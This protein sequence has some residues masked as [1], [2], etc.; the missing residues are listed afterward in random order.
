MEWINQIAETLSLDGN[1]E[2]ALGEGAGWGTIQVPGCWEAQ[3]YDAFAEGPARCRRSVMIPQAW[4]GKH[5]DLEVEAA[6]YACEI[7]CNGIPVGNHKGL[8]TRFVIDLTSAARA[9]Q[10]NLIE[11]II[12]KPGKRYPMRACLAGFLPDL[13]TTFG[14]IWQPAR[15]RALNAS[16]NDVRIEADFSSGTLRVRAQAETFN[17]E[18]PMGSW[19]VTITGPDQQ[20]AVSEFPA[21]PDLLLDQI[22]AAG[23][24][25]AWSPETPHLYR[26]EI[27]YQVEGRV[28]ASA[29]QRV[30]FRRFSTQGDQL[31]LNDQPFMVRGILSWGW[32]P[33]KIAP[34]HDIETARQEMRRVR[35]MGFNLIKLCLFVPNP[36]YFEAADEEG[37]LLWE[38]LPM[39]LPQVSPELRVD[40]PQEYDKITYLTAQHPSVVV[41]SLGCELNQT[42]DA[43][44]LSQLNAVV[45]SRAQDVLLCD[46]SGSGES[47]G[48]LDF[49]YSDFTDYHPY[50][51]LHYFE[52]LLDHWRRDW[53]PPRPWIFGEF[54]DSDSF[55]NQEEL[56]HRHDSRPWWLTRQN[57]VAAWR[58]EAQAAVDWH[59]R[60]RQAETGFSLDEI[61]QISQRQSLMIRKYTLEALRRRRGMGGYVVTGL[62][63]TPISTSGVWDDFLRPKWPEG[64]FL[65][66][67]D[68]DVLCLDVGRRRRWQ[69]GGDR[70]D[71]IDPHTWWAASPAR[72]DVILH[73]ARWDYLPGETL[74]WSIKTLE[75]EKVAEGDSLIE[76]RIRA[77]IPGRA[78]TIYWHTPAL[79]KAAGY[80]LEITLAPG[81][82]S[83]R[84]PVWV[85]PRPGRP[86]F[87]MAV[88]DPSHRL[89]DFGDWLK[90]AAHLEPGDSLAR[91]RL[92]VTTQLDSAVW[93]WIEA[94]GKAL[95]LQQGEGPLPARRCPFWRE[96]VKLLANH[97][98]W[99]YFPHQGFT[100]LQ[101]FGIASDLAFDTPHLLQ[102][103]PAGTRFQPI[104]RRLDAREFH[105]S[106]YLF[107][108]SFGKGR[109]LGCSLRLQGGAGAQAAGLSRNVSGAAMMEALIHSLDT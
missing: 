31:L 81:V 11:F 86:P 75:G 93:K 54:N 47:Y 52:P 15:L 9:G 100:D 63:D 44:L 101:F 37:M 98:I 46:N 1:W 21:Q 19:Q 14:G 23:E 45:R 58:S 48:G 56:D 41:Y 50:Y 17:P 80:W 102:A 4:S 55:R 36:A 10:E 57:P 18:L 92:L 60:M 3:G 71:P 32:D 43:S 26:V 22:V 90:P 97:K 84:W 40:A 77:G 108:A 106:E 34:Y 65:P 20:Q 30:G 109:L 61:V 39:W 33:G 12:Y 76:T 53:Q 107:E 16:L 7:Y 59:E 91:A 105:L 27:A 87:G 99:D 69:H 8:W 42:V 5:I 6:S 74:A 29:K 72:W 68:D 62:R 95:L 49:D 66:F 88:Y 79:A 2:F 94:G 104:L 28:L 73:A 83:N 24:V 35:A 13:A 70:P 25:Q 103:L 51:D 78:A 85:F 64:E 89:D 67:N 38:E 96:A 82:V